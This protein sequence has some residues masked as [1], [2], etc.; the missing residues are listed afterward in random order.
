MSVNKIKAKK[1]YGNVSEDFLEMVADYTLTLPNGRVITFR[2]KDGSIKVDELLYTL[3]FKWD[4]RHNCARYEILSKLQRAKK[5]KVTKGVLVRN[6][7]RPYEVRNM[8]VYA[9]EIRKNYPYMD[10]YKDDTTV[11]MGN[12][13]KGGKVKNILSVGTKQAYEG[14]DISPVEHRTLYDGLDI[15][16]E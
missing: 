2:N 6:H 10:L 14:S 5:E 13:T 4:T 16:E 8:T 9:G 12:F 7:K 15:E 11:L 3:G 1:V